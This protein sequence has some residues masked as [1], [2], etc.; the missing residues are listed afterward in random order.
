MAITDTQQAAQSAAAQQLAP[1]KQNNI[2][3]KLS[4]DIRTPV[5]H[6]R[7]R[8]TPPIQPCYLSRV[9]R[10][11]RSMLSRLRLRRNRQEMR[12]RRLLLHQTMPVTNSRSLKL[13]AIQMA[14]LL[15]WLLRP[16]ISH[17]GWPRA[18]CSISGMAVPK[19]SR[20]GRIA[21]EAARHSGYNR[22]H[23]RFP[24]ISHAGG[25][26]GGCGKCHLRNI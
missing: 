22:D 7:M 23:S 16:M 4:R 6:L 25:C 8:R 17:S 19:Q 1:Q 10:R 21:G 3:L 18:G 13:P 20:R 12:Q 9:R 14:L 15:A 24:R 26:A 11:Q 5:R 2:C